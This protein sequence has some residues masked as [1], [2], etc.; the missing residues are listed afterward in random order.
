MLS[1]DGP[2]LV[3]TGRFFQILSQVGD[4]LRH[5]D[6]FVFDAR[7]ADALNVLARRFGRDDFDASGPGTRISL[8][9]L[10]MVPV[11]VGV[12]DVFHGLGSEFLDLFDEGARRGRFGVGVDDEDDVVEQDDRGVAID[13]VGGLGNGGVDAVG[14]GLDV[15]EVFGGEAG[16]GKEENQN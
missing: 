16:Y 7:Y 2:L 12:D 1:L 9:A 5:G 10:I 3:R 11:K 4:F 8:I 15:E 6:D 13:F 14:H